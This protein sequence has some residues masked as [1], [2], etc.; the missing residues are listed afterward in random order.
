MSISERYMWFKLKW[1]ERI[2]DYALEKF[3]ADAW[4]VSFWEWLYGK[5]Y[6][7]DDEYPKDME[8]PF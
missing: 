8:I 2:S 5:A 6:V 7:S 3:L 1:R 4:P